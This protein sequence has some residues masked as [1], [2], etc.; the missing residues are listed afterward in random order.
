MNKVEVEI[1]KV[2]RKKYKY[3]DKVQLVKTT[4]EDT[5]LK[6]GDRGEVV[7][8]DDMGTVHIKWNNGENLGMCYG[9]DIITSI[10]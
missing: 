9:E 3:G 2:L 5:E 1:V 4:D 7:F 10:L 8:V 6:P